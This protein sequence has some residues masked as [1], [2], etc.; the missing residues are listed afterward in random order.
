MDVLQ[1]VRK[2][3]QRHALPIFALQRA[4]QEIVAHLRVF[5]QQRS[6]QV[7]GDHIFVYHAFIPGFSGIAKPVKHLSKRGMVPD[8]GPPAVVLES[9]HRLLEKRAVQHNISDQALR[10]PLRRDIQ[11]P[12]PFDG[13]FI[14][15]ADTILALGR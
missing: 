15:P 13:L 10:L 7:R 4:L 9:H 6:V 12:Q 14:R 11:D 3:L 1:L 5:R 8:I 2:R